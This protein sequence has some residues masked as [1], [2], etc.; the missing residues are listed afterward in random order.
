MEHR[1]KTYENLN[2]KSFHSNIKIEARESDSSEEDLEEIEA[3]KREQEEHVL[4]TPQHLGK[5]DDEED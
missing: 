3:R 4:N 5:T 1:N 2:K